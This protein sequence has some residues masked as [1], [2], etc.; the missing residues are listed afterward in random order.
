LDL[1]ELGWEADLTIKGAFAI[2]PAVRSA[3]GSL[4]QVLDVQET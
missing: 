1:P 3:I 2:S 4:P